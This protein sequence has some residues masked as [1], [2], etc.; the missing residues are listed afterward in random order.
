MKRFVKT[1]GRIGCDVRKLSTKDFRFSLRVNFQP[2]Q[3]RL[4]EHPL[5]C[6][7]RKPTLRL[8]ITSTDIRMYSREPNLLD[9]LMWR[10]FN[11]QVL[12]KKS[13]PLIDRYSVPNSP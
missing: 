5:K 4:T 8:G 2:G 1:S 11:K 7:L 13:S 3:F 10:S 6:E 9:I 12:A